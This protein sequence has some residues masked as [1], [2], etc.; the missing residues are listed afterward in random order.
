MHQANGQLS[1]IFPGYAIGSNISELVKLIDECFSNRLNISEPL[2]LLKKFAQRQ[3]NVI[4]RLHML[5][6]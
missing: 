5:N 4:Y 3:I 2:K 6:K 1:L